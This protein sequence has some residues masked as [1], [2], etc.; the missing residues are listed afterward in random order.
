MSVTNYNPTPRNI[1]EE[2]IRLD[3]VNLHVRWDKNSP[4]DEK[5][6]FDNEHDDDDD[7]GQ[8]V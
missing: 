1:P 8:C 2:Q 7:E 3:T 5:R 4:Y 6:S